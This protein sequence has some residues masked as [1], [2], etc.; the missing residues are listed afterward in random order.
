MLG[1]PVSLCRWDEGLTGPSATAARLTP[2]RAA[3]RWYCAARYVCL[4]RAA[5]CAASTSV[6]R[7]Q[8]LPRRVRPLRR[9]P[10]LSWLPGHIPAHDAR[11][12]AVGNLPMSVS[13]ESS[14]H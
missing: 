6:A 11:C 8:G 7:S 10:A 13:R 1:L 14:R 2:R 4:V 5:A 12:L 3:R 9:L